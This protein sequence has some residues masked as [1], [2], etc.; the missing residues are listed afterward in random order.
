MS[1]LPERKQTGPSKDYTDLLNKE[2]KFG[3]GR[4]YEFIDFSPYTSS[5]SDATFLY[6][7]IDITAF[8]DVIKENQLISENY[9]LY[10][11]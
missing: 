4:I 8:N 9:I 6:S 5:T 7:S 2:T 1:Y 10:F 11:H 3:F